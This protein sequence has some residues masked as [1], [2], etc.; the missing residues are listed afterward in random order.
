MTSVV[1]F[2][3]QPK[4]SEFDIQKGFNEKRLALVPL[5]ENLLANHQLFKDNPISVTFSE[6]GVG[7]LVCIVDAN[8]QK[9]VLKVPLGKT[10]ASGEVMFLKVWE[11]AGVKVPQI[12]E[13]GLIA[14]LPYILMEFIE[15]P[16]LSDVSSEDKKDKWSSFELGRI[17]RTMHVPKAVG[18]G[19]V[20]DDKAEFQ[21][22]E[23]WLGSKK[24][25]EGIEYIKNNGLLPIEESQILRVFSVLTDHAKNTQSS[26]CHFD[27]G[28]SNIFAT[29]PVTVFDPNPQ[30]NNGYL[31]L[32]LSVFNSITAGTDPKRLIEGYFEHEACDQKVLFASVLVSSFV[33]LPP[34]HKKGKFDNIENMKRYFIENQHF[35]EE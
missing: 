6:K 3:N 7:S 5:I 24:I 35:L 22:F 10:V 19:S 30:F 20:I 1:T 26:Y 14:D 27:F 33:K 18:Y 12:I 28:A 2:L 11:Q 8:N 29:V 31:D 34:R 17:L 13:E 16:I 32:G 9:I 23:D 15:A 21:T 25:R 4:L